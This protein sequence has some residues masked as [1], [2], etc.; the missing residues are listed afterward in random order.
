MCVRVRVRVYVKVRVRVTFKVIDLDSRSQAVT[1]TLVASLN[2]SVT[3]P[4]VTASVWRACLDH[5]VTR[6]HV[7]SQ[8]FSPTAS[9]ATVA[10]LNGTMSSV[11]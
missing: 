11:R 1:A 9:A 4:V 7:D 8:E 2:I 3:K 10:L 6:A 5:V